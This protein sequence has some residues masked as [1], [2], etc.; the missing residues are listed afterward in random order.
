M[1]SAGW[2]TLVSVL[3]PM[4]LMAIP[5]GPSVLEVDFSRPIGQV[6][7]LQGMNGGPIACGEMVDLS[8][9]HRELGIPLMRLH[10]CHWPNPDVVDI[11]VVFPRV[12][13]D[14]ALPES[15]DFSR[16]DDYIQS[17]LD[18]GAR[19]VYRLGESIE[20]GKKK[21]HVHPPPSPEKWAAICEGI[22]RHYRQGWAGGLRHDIRYW[23]VWNE[24]ENR[25]AM[26]TGSDEDYFRLYEATSRALKSRFPEIKVGG[27]AVGAPG[28]VEG[29]VLKPSPFLAGF[30]AR[31]KDRSLPLDFF[32]WHRYSDDPFSFAEEARAVRRHLDGLGLRGT[33]CHLNEW[34]YLPGNDWGPILLGGQGLAREKCYAEMGGPRGA[35]FVACAL[36]SLED[37]P[38]DM[39]NFYRSDIDGFGLFTSHGVPKKVF[40]A[41]RAFRALTDLPARA[42]VRG[43]EP[44]RLAVCAGMDRERSQGTVLVSSF[45]SPAERIT[46]RLQGLPW[47]GPAAFE[48]SVVDAERDLE[49]VE[50]GELP[51]PDL[52]YSRDLKAPSVLLLSLRRP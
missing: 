28:K 42:E 23:E 38:V 44:G 5:S 47:P 30:L 2:L 50:R 14:P 48:A 1:R 22:V 11:H 4:S 32:S 15:Y 7:P 43:G 8:Q 45:S 41:F 25:P 6:R 39:A 49:V 16:T 21:Y 37:S 26:W 13:A 24:P 51:S 18:T 40:H 9:R 3:R 31:V 36:I 52:V 29:G 20:H 35:A 27:P 12:D 33:E 46:L 19:I 34:N 10:D 17:I